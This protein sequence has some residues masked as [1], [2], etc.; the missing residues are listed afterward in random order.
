[1]YYIYHYFVICC[2]STKIEIKSSRNISVQPWPL[3][4]SGTGSGHASRLSADL[5][6][7]NADL[8]KPEIGGRPDDKVLRT[9]Q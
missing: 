8:G 4:S 6:T 9:I 1:M 7:I 3:S 5:L 2:S